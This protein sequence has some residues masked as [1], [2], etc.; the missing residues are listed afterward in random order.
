[1]RKKWKLVDVV[2]TRRYGR[3]GGMNREEKDKKKGRKCIKFKRKIK[4]N[5]EGVRYIKRR[6]GKK[7]WKGLKDE[8]ERSSAKEEK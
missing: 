8:N 7:R 2:G 3:K 5:I 6:G 4:G 1:M